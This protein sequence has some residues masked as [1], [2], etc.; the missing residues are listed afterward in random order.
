MKMK[1]TDPSGRGS[2]YSSPRPGVVG[3]W[4]CGWTEANFVNATE[5]LEE[6]RPG[7]NEEIVA[8]AHYLV[9]WLHRLPQIG[10]FCGVIFFNSLLA[11]L[12]LFGV[13]FI[14]EYMR[15]YMFGASLLLSQLSKIWGYIKVPAFIV[16]AV[17]LWPQGMFLPIALAVFLVSSTVL[18]MPINVIAS[19]IVHTMFSEKLAA[20]YGEDWFKMT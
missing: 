7:V 17:S 15:F 14:L 18:M 1:L 10:F 20:Q 3:V 11:G 4:F 5:A 12:L 2:L 13:A 9:L 16:A 6:K 8:E 19:R